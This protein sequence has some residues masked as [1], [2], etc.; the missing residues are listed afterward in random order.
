MTSTIAER[1]VPADADLPGSGWLAIDEG[2]ASDSDLGAAA[3]LF[4]C[5]GPDFPEDD[6]VST[7]ASPHFV[8]LPRRLLHGIGVAF[9]SEG[10]AEAAEVILRSTPFVE[11]L[12]LSVAADLDAQPVEAELLAVDVDVTAAGHRVRFTG[13]D[14]HGVRPVHLDIA[15][16]RVGALV[17]LLWCGDTPE[18]FPS[19][20]LDHVLAR[21]RTRALR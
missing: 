12:G 16:L 5:V 10:A 8:R 11:C 1:I 13:G 9:D 21:V 2:F 17:G 19:H 3:E 14:A 18:P 15:V 7:A 4:D 20:D 6:V